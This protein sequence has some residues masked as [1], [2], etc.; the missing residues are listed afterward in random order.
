MF[1]Q[2]DF[3]DPLF[4]KCIKL[5]TEAGDFILFDSRTFHSNRYPQKPV[6]RVCTY[7]CMLPK[8]VIPEG[9]E[10]FKRQAFDE[11]RTSTHHAGEGFNLFP[12]PYGLSEAKR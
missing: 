4:Q 11:K 8:K 5:N 2:K 9:L 6:L 1:N 12:V 7:I 10:K 3:E